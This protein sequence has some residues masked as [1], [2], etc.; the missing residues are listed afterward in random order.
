MSILENPCET[1]FGH[2]KGFSLG[3]SSRFTEY[4]LL[5][6]E[7]PTSTKYDTQK[8][9]CFARQPK[10]VAFSFGSPVRKDRANIRVADS[11]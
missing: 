11:F 2:R 7:S 3:A 1:T 8:Y 6:G 10:G 9:S 4:K 5:A